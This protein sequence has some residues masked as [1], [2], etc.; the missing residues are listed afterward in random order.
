MKNIGTYTAVEQQHIN[1]AVSRWEQ[2]YLMIL[3]L[4]TT[5]GVMGFGLSAGTIRNTA[6]GDPRALIMWSFLYLIA[7][8]LV[9][10]NRQRVVSLLRENILVF[11]LTGYACVSFFW[12]A[13]PE[14]TLRRAIALM[15]TTLLAVYLGAR[16]K[17]HEIFRLLAWALGISIVACII[18][19]IFFPSCGL[20]LCAGSSAW[21]GIYVHKNSFGRMLLL[22]SII[23][24][25][26][27]FSPRV[28]KKLIYLLLTVVSIVLIFLSRSMTSVIVLTSVIIALPVFLW[29]KLNQFLRISI[30]VFLLE[31][32]ALILLMNIFDLSYSNVD[33]MLKDY[34]G[35]GITLSGRTLVWQQV[36]QEIKRSFFLGFGYDAF[37]VFPGG[38]STI[39]RSKLSYEAAI[40]SHNGTLDLWLE[41][42]L[43]G[44]IL[45]FFLLIQ[46]AVRLIRLIT[47]GAKFSE[48]IFPSAFLIFF[49]I[50]NFVENTVLTRNSIF[51]IL[52]VATL[53]HIGPS[54]VS[55]N[56][57]QIEINYSN[58]RKENSKM[59]RLKTLLFSWRGDF[60]T[61]GWR[62]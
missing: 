61:G 22:S 16:T 48:F 10:H 29:F 40:H 15:G 31:I 20:Q 55:M 53:M 5:S 23:W 45:Y 11:L 27:V 49:F 43:V 50:I 21:R 35:K 38:P 32:L 30:A 56:I 41:L 37:W 13:V 24:I 62:P 25:Y 7:A 42:G 51:W 17:P 8:F 52:F 36:W 60:P 6:L 58:K 57:R 39:I 34:L 44:V 46:Y 19:V 9:F 1:T 12:S 4:F 59:T 3:F 54:N 18:V 33:D 47:S 2:A 14:V 26:F 28:E